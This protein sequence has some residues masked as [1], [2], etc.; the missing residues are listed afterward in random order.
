MRRPPVFDMGAFSPSRPGIWRYR[1]MFGLPGNAPEVSLGEGQ[2]PLVWDEIFGLPVAFK[3]EN[4]NPSGSFKD[5]GSPLLVSLLAS[6]GIRSAV[7]D[8]SGN[9]GASFAAYA[10]RAGMSAR[11]FVP[12]YT[13]GPKREQ[14]AAYGAQVIP[15]PGSRA[16]TARA[17]LDEADAGQ[18]YA[19]HVYMPFGLPGMSTIAYELFEQL[20]TAPGSIIVP[21][22]H[23]SL[24]LGIARGFQA[25]Y[26]AGLSKKK[27]RLIAVQ[28]ARCAPLWAE[29]HQETRPKIRD[30]R[31]AGVRITH[32]V[33][34]SAVLEAI[35][36][37]QGTVLMVEEAPLLTGWEALARR[38]FHVEITSALVWDAVRQVS[39]NIPEPLVAVLTGSGLKESR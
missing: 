14:I 23:G 19:S 5:R 7:E 2:T 18:V 15:V 10:A 16:D 13:S 33:R 28:A 20:G 38:G 11:V 8:S 35:G 24:L 30:T 1:D 4:L 6:R 37:M 21:V 9:A 27:P 34:K 31:A 17:V 3:C 29:F 22:G 25:L 36:S 39:R 32:P 26:E 12:A